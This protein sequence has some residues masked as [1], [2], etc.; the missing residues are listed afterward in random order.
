MQFLQDNNLNWQLLILKNAFARPIATKKIR[1]TN[2]LSVIIGQMVSACL[3]TLKSLIT[4]EK[5][6]IYR[7]EFF[8]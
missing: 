7:V 8:L 1:I 2:N 3:R 5:G 4:P 6:A